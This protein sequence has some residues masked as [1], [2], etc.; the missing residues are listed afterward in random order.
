MVGTCRVYAPGHF[1]GAID[2]GS[3]LE[4]Y[5]DTVD[6]DTLIIKDPLA[7]SAKKE[8]VA[9][10]SSLATRS[11]LAEGDKLSVETHSGPLELTIAHRIG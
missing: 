7:F 11:G 3:E 6:H 8:S 2:L 5:T 4:L 9:I 10:T 1:T